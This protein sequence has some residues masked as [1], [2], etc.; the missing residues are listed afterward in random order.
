MNR[1]A[2]RTLLAAL[3]FALAGPSDASVQRGDAGDVFEVDGRIPAAALLTLPTIDRPTRIEH[4][5]PMLRR[6]DGRIGELD[7]R[8]LNMLRRFAQAR[9]SV[10]PAAEHVSTMHLLTADGRDTLLHLLDDGGQVVFVRS[11]ADGTVVTLPRARLDALAPGWDRHKDGGLSTALPAG[12]VVDLPKPYVEARIGLDSRTVVD[13]L[14]G[15]DRVY[16]KSGLT[17]DLEEEWL[18]V[19]LPKGHD[20]ATPAGIMVWV[21]PMARWRIPA[22]FYGV[23]D[24]L[25]LI[26]CGAD[27]AGNPRNVTE[28]LQLMFDAVE[29]VRAR[30]AV[31][32]KRIYVTGFSGGGRCSSM[33]HLGWPEVFAGSVPIVGL[34]SYHRLDSQQP[35]RVIPAQVGRPSGRRLDLARANRMWAFTGET[36]GNRYEMELRHGRLEF[37]G[38][39]AR[40][41]TVPGIGHDMPPVDELHE[42]VRWVDEPRREALQGEAAEA[43]DALTEHDER[44]GAGT[45]ET[46]PARASLVEITRKWPWTEAAWR[47]AERLGYERP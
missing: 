20:G 39:A 47:A 24:E 27:N 46:G 1:F 16:P 15:G 25:G 18:W 22:H 6:L 19:R 42:A 26:A 28:R 9:A 35:G 21:S 40:L 7:R 5:S 43:L 23:L 14:H 45:P 32:E 29:N 4:S 33:L 38:F 37:D 34:N 2:L 13:R 10:G 41:T 31:D 11:P 30:W 44:F 3:L 17:R 36:D 12:E 8:A